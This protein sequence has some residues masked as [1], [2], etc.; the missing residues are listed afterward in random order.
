EVRGGKGGQYGLSYRLTDAKQHA[1]EG[2]YLFVVRGEGFDG[3][4]YRFN[5]L[6]LVTDRREYAAGDKVKLLINTNQEGG[7]VLLFARP[8]GVYQQPK[9]L[10]LQG[11]GIEEDIAVLKKDMRNFFVEALTVAGGRVHTEVREV[12]VPPEKRVLNV[13]VLPSQKEYK[14]GQKATVTVKV[15]DFFGKPFVGSLVLSVYNRSVDYIA[16]GSNVPE[17]REFFWKWRRHHYPHTE[18]SV[19]QWFNHLL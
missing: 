4:D 16:G 7:V 2:G 10:R 3:R 18:A 8:S 14:P 13:E 1:I 19:C 9:V 11:T 12:V 5:D 15:T 6:E 17:I